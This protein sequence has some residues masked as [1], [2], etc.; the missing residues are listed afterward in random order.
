LITAN[1]G[2]LTYKLQ[3]LEL[4]PSSCV[5]VLET[6]IEVDVVRPDSSLESSQPVLKPP[7]YGKAESGMVEEGNY[8]Y[9]KFYI[10]NDTWDKISAEDIRVEVRI[11]AETS[12]GDTDLYISNH[13]RT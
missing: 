5:S 8:N 2:I 13:P 1:H 9:Y 11:E 6:D 12:N 7:I 3:V 10:D 4:R